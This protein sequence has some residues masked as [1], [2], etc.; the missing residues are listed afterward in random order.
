MTDLKD[1]DLA[2][3][4]TWGGSLQMWSDVGM[5]DREV[6]LYRA[7]R[8][9]LR[10]IT[11]VTYGDSRDRRIDTDLD[12]IRVVC[13]RWGVHR[14]LYRRLLPLVYPLL[15]RGPAVAMSNQVPGSEIAMTAA[16]I[17]GKKFVARCGYLY[18]EFMA[19]ANGHDS[20]KAA[21][22]R[23]LERKVFAK[24]DRVV[25]TTD[26]MRHSVIDGYGLP[27]KRVNVIPNYVE[28]ERFRPIPGS[29]RDPRRVCCIGA[30]RPQKNMFALLDA[31]D[32]LDV[33]LVI[34][35][36]GGQRDEIDR[37]VKSRGLNVRL[38]GNM[39]HRELPSILNDAGLFI[40]PSHYEGHPKALLEA[41]ACGLPVIATNVPGIREIIR[42]K[43]NGF[44]AGTSPRELRDAIK[45]VM[46]DSGLRARMGCRARELVV[47]R[48]AL[49]R[50]VDMQLEMLEKVVSS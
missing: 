9:E 26:A 37:R 49:P 35:G 23:G 32:G 8:P 43:D 7:L 48:F 12:G 31:V 2:M 19:H 25:V 41:M 30:L 20:A 22:A 24:A 16:R 18:S 4:F 1:I 34:V 39:P 5:L 15:W 21:Y 46:A 42:H 6:A 45:A 27:E 47:E 14:R 44:L 13:N 50:I 36:D 11:F 40:L 17:A 33:E 38:M 3:F 10:R 28:T 29:R